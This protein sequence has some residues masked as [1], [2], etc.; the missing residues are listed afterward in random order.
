MQ[1]NH[2]W[3]YYD[4]LYYTLHLQRSVHGESMWDMSRWCKYSYRSWLDKAYWSSSYEAYTKSQLRNMIMIERLLSTFTIGGLFLALYMTSVYPTAALPM[5]S[6]ARC[7]PFECCQ[8]CCFCCCCCCFQDEITAPYILVI[9]LT[10]E[11]AKKER[12]CTILLCLPTIFF[13]TYPRSQNMRD[14]QVPA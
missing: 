9:S 11:N 10:T 2:S 13:V 14:A 7:S 1:C 3:A 6:Y 4:L 8:W 5:L 12:I